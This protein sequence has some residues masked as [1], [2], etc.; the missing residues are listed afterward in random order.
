MAKPVKL[1]TPEYMH[2]M[3]AKSEVMMAAFIKLDQVL[4]QLQTTAFE[5]LNA[6]GLK[7]D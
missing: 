6:Q 1:P 7:P 3:Q 5:Q 4:E 2:K